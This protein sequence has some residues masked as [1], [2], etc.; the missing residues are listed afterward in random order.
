[1]YIDEDGAGQI[2]DGASFFIQ[3]FYIQ[4]FNCNLLTKNL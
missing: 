4:Y 2:F 1:M 3:P